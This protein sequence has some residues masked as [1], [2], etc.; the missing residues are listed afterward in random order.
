MKMRVPGTPIRLAITCAFL[1]TACALGQDRGGTP[2]G[3]GIMVIGD[4]FSKADASGSLEYWGACNSKE[5][6]PDFPKLKRISDHQGSPVDLLREIFSVDPKMRVSQDTDGKIRMVEEDVPTDL[7]E[8]EIDH[9]QF[10]VEYHGPNAAIVAIMQTP[11]VMAFRRK[12][13]V[14][15]PAGLGDIAG[16]PSETYDPAKGRVYGGLHDVTVKQALDHVLGRF[17]GF[18]LYENCKSPGGGRI[19][20]FDFF[21]NAPNAALAQ[22]EKK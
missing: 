13:N 7:L 21:E 6:Y 14:G 18:W 11:E 2:P 22:I 16:Y 9:V 3:Y 15:P 12:H 1:L 17:H 19:V 10:P 5:F 4:V 8:V 20:F